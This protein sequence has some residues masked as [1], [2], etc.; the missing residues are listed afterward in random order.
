MCAIDKQLSLTEHKAFGRLLREQKRGVSCS[1]VVTE[2]E[3]SS[4]FWDMGAYGLP[5]K[6]EK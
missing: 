3:P 2:K 5:K 1:I 6:M 4:P